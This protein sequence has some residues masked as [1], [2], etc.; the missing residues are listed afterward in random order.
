MNLGQHKKQFVEEHIDGAILSECDEEVLCMELGI[1][2]RDER[3]KLMNIITG[4]HSVKI[5]SCPE[6]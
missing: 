5:Y 3:N 1:S 2:N 4:S 6:L